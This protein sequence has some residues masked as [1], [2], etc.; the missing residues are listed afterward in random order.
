MSALGRLLPLTD[1]PEDVCLQFLGAH[2]LPVS[3]CNPTDAGPLVRSPP[4][5]VIPGRPADSGV[6]GNRDRLGSAECGHQLRDQ[7]EQRGT[8]LGVAV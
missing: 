7:S 3:K 6:L 2:A 8:A 5:G 1:V 4:R